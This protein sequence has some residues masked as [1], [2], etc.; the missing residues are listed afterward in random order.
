VLLR[1]WGGKIFQEALQKFRIKE[2]THP[3]NK[4]NSGTE[5]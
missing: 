1:H 3:V 4:Q 5:K 2:I